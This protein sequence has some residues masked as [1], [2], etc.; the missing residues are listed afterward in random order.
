MSGWCGL[1][2]GAHHHGTD[3]EGLS[4]VHLTELPESLGP[5][6]TTDTLLILPLAT[7]NQTSA[8]SSLQSLASQSF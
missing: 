7:L 3:V 2:L 6:A 4:G 8:H 1:V 5:P